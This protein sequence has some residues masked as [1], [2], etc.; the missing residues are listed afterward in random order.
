MIKTLTN[1]II[2][3][4]IL[5]IPNLLFG[6][7][8]T[9]AAG[10]WTPY[11]PSASTGTNDVII[12]DVNCDMPHS[13]V[14]NNLTINDGMS[15]KVLANPV[16]ILG[17][18]TLGRQASY[19][20]GLNGSY[21]T[22]NGTTTISTQGTASQ[23]YYNIWSSPFSANS[24]DL[25]SSFPGVNPC[26][27]YTYEATTQSWKFD[28][29]VPFTTTCNGNSVTFDTQDVLVVADGVADGKFDLGRGYFIPGD[30]P[31]TRTFSSSSNPNSGV[32]N[33]PLYGS[34]LAI[35]GGNDWNLIGNPYISSIGVGSTIQMNSSL[36]NA[37]YVY[38]A[39]SGLYDTYNSTQSFK[40]ST[41]QGF[42]VDATSV[43][44]GFIGNFVFDNT[45]RRSYN[46][47]FRG[48][49]ATGIFY[50]SLMNDSISDQIQVLTNPECLDGYDKKYDA[51]KLMNN[52]NLNLA[53]MIDPNSGFGPEPFVFNG[54]KTFEQNDSK[55]VDLFVQVNG[56]GTFTLALD[57]T[58]NLDEEMEIVLMDHELNIS[59]DLESNS[60]SFS[61]P[62]ADTLKNRFS[63]Q[64]SYD[65]TNVTSIQ[66]VSS[67]TNLDIYVINSKVNIKS[68]S[69]NIQ[70]IEVKVYDVLGKI[71]L[72]NSILST[73]YSFDIPNAND[74][75][76]IVK[77]LDNKG[78][79]LTKK[80]LIQQ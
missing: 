22:V 3:L 62:N 80:I 32:L 70:L 14:V 48:S 78:N 28:Y 13:S 52:I 11:A 6:Q 38:N 49:D 21:L 1:L 17:N 15:V 26:D 33:V 39:I 56:A 75:I 30:I 67:N 18:L 36:V 51:R 16:T 64:L 76:Y 63:L 34:S 57:S 72:N 2:S 42:F 5:S 8:L 55:T 58:I 4:A 77:V 20:I 29:S 10:V 25:L 47:N 68:N 66:S 24:L 54:L 59:T 79:Y 41:C 65:S 9:Y 27:V 71:V 44:D 31:S 60:Y 53:S 35:A 12:D 73:S 45:L 23:G 74:G 7:T 69:D 50:F 40:L 61:V 37:I 43:V 19:S 46:S